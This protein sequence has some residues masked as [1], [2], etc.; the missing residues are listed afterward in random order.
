MEAE[1]SPY[2]F[3]A[4][5]CDVADTSKLEQFRQKRSEWLDLYEGD[6]D[7]NIRKQIN[8]LM[9]SDAVFRA[10]NH[11]R[12]FGSENQPT[13]SHNRALAEF[14]DNGY[15]ASQALA[16]SKLTDPWNPD[17]SK[18]VV[19]LPRLLRDIREN[20]GLITRE[21]FICF[22]GLPYDYEKVKQRHYAKLTSDELRAF[23][24]PSRSGPE[25]FHSSEVWHR[26][27]DRYAR[28]NSRSRGDLIDLEILDRLDAVLKDSSIKKIR[29]FRN[30][31]VGHAADRISRTGHTLEKLGFSLNDFA[32]AQRRIIIVAEVIGSLLGT[33]V[34][35]PIAAA[36]FDVFEFLDRPIA[37][38]KDSK[39]LSALWDSLETSR[40]EW[41]NRALEDLLNGIPP[42][43]EE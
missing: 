3:P 42:V 38:E 14:I 26:A 34:A 43:K 23:V 20:L 16:I 40:D 30:K 39:T 13:A 36:Q 19:S 10:L 11:A 17:S 29:I 27:F 33:T 4:S 32:D 25:A 24:R 22:D 12:R 15:V 9:W 41:R 8:D 6:P 7:H 28:S 2:S 31:Y 21:Y 37:G 35:N 1:P 18:N 5:E